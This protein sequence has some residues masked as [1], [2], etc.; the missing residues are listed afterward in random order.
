MS[1]DEYEKLPAKDREHFFQCPD[2]G[3]TFDFRILDDVAF[4]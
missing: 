1:P 4:I 3:E 2:C